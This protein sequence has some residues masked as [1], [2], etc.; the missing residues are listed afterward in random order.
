VPLQEP[1]PPDAEPPNLPE[2]DQARP[3]HISTRDEKTYKANDDL[4]HDALLLT[5]F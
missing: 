4:F 1:P 2:A 3:A 5:A